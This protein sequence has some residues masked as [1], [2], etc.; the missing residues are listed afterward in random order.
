MLSDELRNQYVIGFS[1]NDQISKKWHD[2]KVK[3]NLPK[4]KKKELGRVYVRAANGYY[5][6]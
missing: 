5:S 6:Q 3:V 2:I 1:A 4:E